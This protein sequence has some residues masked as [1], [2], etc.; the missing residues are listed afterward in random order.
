MNGEPIPIASPSTGVDEEAA[1]LRV[2]RS[3]RLAQGPEVAALESEF[4]S[5]SGVEHAVGVANA[6]LGIYAALLA[7]GIR[8]GDEVLV[9]AFTFAATAGAVVATG[10]SPVFVDIDDQYLFDVEDAA[11]R[12]TPKTTA[13]APVHLYG[14]MVDMDAV[15]AFA[16]A[17]G[18]GIVE[19]AAQAHL[20]RRGGIGAGSTG[21]GV[22]S[23]YA[24]KNMMSGEG[25]IVTTNDTSIADHLRLLRD[26]GMSHRYQHDTF[27]LNLRM[28]E[29]EAAIARVQLAK[30]P[31]WTEERRRN[32]A[33]FDQ[34]LP[35][36]WIRPPNPEGAEHV[37][38]QY[39]VRV[40]PDRRDKT[41]QALRDRGVGA[42][43][44]YPS[45][46]PSQ[47]AY[48]AHRGQDPYPLAERAAA[49][50]L[51][52]PVHPAVDEA[53]AARIVATAHEIEDL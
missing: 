20:A 24:T 18:L 12:V 40:D 48:Q 26:H 6:T 39:T 17:H 50:V 31:E 47:P 53:A 52:L 4:A 51:S 43:I 2:L 45:T 30:L 15:K 42:E 10:A 5:V 11:R 34:E 21:I 13:V 19:D 36:S 23:L 41:V 46:V 3:G 35:G 1:V 7:S 44:Y 9:P 25:G 14:L 29:L 8:P 27:G 37:Y 16:D 33:R 22:F 49:G 38:H 32:A 28:S